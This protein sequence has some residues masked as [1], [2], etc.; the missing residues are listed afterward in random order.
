MYKIFKFYLIKTI[1][2]ELNWKKQYTIK[3]K[4]FSQKYKSYYM[5]NQNQTNIL[6]KGLK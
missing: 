5:G 3:K 1:D 4:H 2:F 6:D